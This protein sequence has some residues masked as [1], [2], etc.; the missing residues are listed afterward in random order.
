MRLCPEYFTKLHNPIR[1]V[2]DPTLL[3]A[4]WGFLGAWWGGAA[5][6]YI[7]GLSATLGPRPQLTPRELLAPLALLVG[8]VAAVTALTGYGVWEYAKTLGVIL[9]SDTSALVPVKRHRGLLAVYASSAVGGI[10][11]CVGSTP[12]AAGARRRTANARRIFR[13]RRPHRTRT[14]RS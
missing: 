4:C 11:L 6:G 2:N 3:A 9:D 8:A 5:L 10:A 7:A 1:G 13:S 12:N 14:R